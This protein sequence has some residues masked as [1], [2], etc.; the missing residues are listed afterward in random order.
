[1]QITTD[2]II[3]TKPD[4]A[5]RFAAAIVEG[6]TYSFAHPEESCTLLRKHAPS[7]DQDVCLTELGLVKTLAL[8]DETNANGIGYMS[9]AGVQGT[10]DVMKEYMGLKA[11]ITPEETFDM[12]FLPKAGAPK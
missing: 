4:L 3:A 1:M 12:G 2:E 7:V 6:V 10:I 5:K 9:K 11:A 8:T